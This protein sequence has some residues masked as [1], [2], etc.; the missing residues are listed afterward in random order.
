M[1]NMKGGKVVSTGQVVVSADGKTRTLSLN[2]T[3]AAGKKVSSV[4]A[5]D[6]Q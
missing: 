4:A 1:S 2:G 5:Y 3:D 6:K